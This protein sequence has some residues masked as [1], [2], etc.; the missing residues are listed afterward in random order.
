MKY[1]LVDPAD[2]VVRY[3]DESRLDLDAGTRTG[4]RWLPVNEVRTDTSTGPDTI[5]ERPA[6]VVLPT[7]V[8]RETII[9]D[10]TAL[11]IDAEADEFVLNTMDQVW[12]KAIFRLINN[13]P[14]P[15]VT[16]AQFMAWIKARYQESS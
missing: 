3:V 5:E 2:Q 1:A 10:K 13:P 11:E 15:P 7:E 6:P 16:K 14:T 4:W 8:R 9:R 12:A